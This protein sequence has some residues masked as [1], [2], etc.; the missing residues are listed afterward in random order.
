[1]SAGGTIASYIPLKAK[2]ILTSIGHVEQL[3]PSRVSTFHCQILF[4][5]DQESM[6]MQDQSQGENTVSLYWFRPSRGVTTLRPV[7][8][9]YALV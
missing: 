3:C 2:L 8:M 1:M 9:Y 7:S 6:M 4:V 5:K